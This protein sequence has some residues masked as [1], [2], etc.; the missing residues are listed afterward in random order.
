VNRPDSVDG[1][2]VS[3]VA[4]TLLPG[5][6]AAAAFGLLRSVRNRSDLRHREI[7]VAVTAA[8]IASGTLAP[9]ARRGIEAITGDATYGRFISQIGTAVAAAY[10]DS[11]MVRSARDHT[12]SE[13]EV[14]VRRRRMRRTLAAM[15]VLFAVNRPTASE[16]QIPTPALYLPVTAAYWLVFSGFMARTAAELAPLA[17]RTSKMAPQRSFRL[18][19]GGVAAGAGVI[20]VF[21][22]QFF[23]ATAVGLRSRR[24]PE[25]LRGVRA[26]NV[27]QVG[28]A[29]IALGACLPSTV[30]RW[31]ATRPKIE[32][33]WTSV[34]LGPLWRHVQKGDSAVTLSVGMFGKPEVR[35]L[36]RVVEIQDGF[37]RL[38]NRHDPT[39]RLRAAAEKVGHE[40]GLDPGQRG[41]LHRAAL[42]RYDLDHPRP[43]RESPP[44]EQGPVREMFASSGRGITDFRREARQLLRIRR[45]LN[46]S[47][48]PALVT[49]RA[50]TELDSKETT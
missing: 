46:G 37:D 24:F 32:D 43:V 28:A 41:A 16:L 13:S 29:S 15:T 30:V 49:Q 44:S 40:R 11:V 38:A 48:L 36:R 50:F 25:P 10:G 12:E 3:R 4:R 18:G 5:F 1:A 20:G 6:C 33:A 26:Q 17:Y 23:A 45:L 7:G 2:P 27:I 42:L 34:R 21:Y 8:A 31:Q 47:Y 9:T 19:L 39:S 22:G 35:L 14:R